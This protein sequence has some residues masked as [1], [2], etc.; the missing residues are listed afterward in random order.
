MT[1][2][3][4]LDRP[5]QAAAQAA[6]LANVVNGSIYFVGRATGWIVANVPVFGDVT[7]GYPNVVFLTI[8]PPFVAAGMLT[9]LARW[10]RRPWPAFMAIAAAVFI[11]MIP[12]PFG[13]EGAPASMVWLLQLM[14]VVVAVAVV[15]LLRRSVR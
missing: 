7:L 6:I 1:R 5:W 12:G 10:L 11:A 4:T 13:L 15:V 2:F 9:L 3:S 8:A 14:H